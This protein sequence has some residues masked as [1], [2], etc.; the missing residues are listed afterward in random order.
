MPPAIKPQGVDFRLYGRFSDD[1]AHAA[2]FGKPVDE[3]IS[4]RADEHEVL[5]D[6]PLPRQLVDQFRTELPL[7]QEASSR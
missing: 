6:S 4:W 5:R 3:V 2:Q 1:Q 7:D